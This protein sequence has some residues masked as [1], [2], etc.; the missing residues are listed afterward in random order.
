MYGNGCPFLYLKFTLG[1]NYLSTKPISK[2]ETFLWLDVL[3]I[4]WGPRGIVLLSDRGGSVSAQKQTSSM[5]ASLKTGLIHHYLFSSRGSTP[6]SL[7]MEFGGNSPRRM[8][9]GVRNWPSVQRGLWW[10]SQGGNQRGLSLVNSCCLLRV[11]QLTRGPTLVL[12]WHPTV[13]EQNANLGLFGKW[14][15]LFLFAT[16]LFLSG[17]R[18]TIRFLISTALHQPRRK[19]WR[20]FCPNFCYLQGSEVF[21]AL[22]ILIG[23][24]SLCNNIVTYNAKYLCF[25][26]FPKSQ[27]LETRVALFIHDTLVQ[28]RLHW[29]QSSGCY[30]DCKDG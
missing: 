16:T 23:R 27:S 21:C 18:F 10:R 29:K 8:F 26:W 14:H 30:G 19:V 1:H 6:A 20:W 5:K 15:S 25:C 7:P 22:R 11:F 12:M 9:Q 3:S 4:S 24:E 17:I 13:C 28:P 2:W